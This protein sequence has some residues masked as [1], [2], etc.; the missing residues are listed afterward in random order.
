MTEWEPSGA[1]LYLPANAVRA[2]GEL[3]IEPA[4][5]A[6][7]GPCEP[8]RRPPQVEASVSDELARQSKLVRLGRLTV[9]LRDTRNEAKAVIVRGMPPGA[10]RP[11]SS[12]VWAAAPF[13]GRSPRG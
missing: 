4:G 2:L 10:G 7:A 1:G 8:Y 3:D 11:R 13:R 5:A 9:G 12:R 6:R